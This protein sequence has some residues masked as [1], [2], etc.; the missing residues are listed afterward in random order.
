VLDDLALMWLVMTA[1]LVCVL[2]VVMG[3][4]RLWR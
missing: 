3:V 1:T 2:L 4:Q